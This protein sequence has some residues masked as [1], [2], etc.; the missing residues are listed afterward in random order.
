MR[1]VD[2]LDEQRVLEELLEDSKPLLPRSCHH[3]DYLLAAP[4]RYRPYPRGSRFRRADQEDGVFY[5]SDAVE[6]AIAETAFYKVLF[7]LVEAPA[8]RLPATAVEHLAFSVDCASARSVDLSLPPFG[9]DEAL[10]SRTDY[11]PCQVLGE[12]AR[13]AGVEIIR[14]R[15]LRD[16]AGGVNVAL[17]APRA[18]SAPAPIDRQTWSL[19]VRRDRIQA[20]REFPALDIEHRLADFAADPRVASTVARS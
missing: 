17:L 13:A 19:F 8:M 15:S 10:R 5:A 2:G 18:F 1:L 4:F 14:Y 6:T 3:L 20:R 7:F 12:R 11:G 9:T 16:P